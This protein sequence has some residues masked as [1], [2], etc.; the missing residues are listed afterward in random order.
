MACAVKSKYHKQHRSHNLRKDL[1]SDAHT[2]MRKLWGQ[3]GAAA[4]RFRK[5]KMGLKAEKRTRRRH[6]EGTPGLARAKLLLNR[7]QRSAQAEQLQLRSTVAATFH[8]M[9]VELEVKHRGKQSDSAQ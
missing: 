8:S 7:W 6:M 5:A 1:D 9:L 3:H 2:F 4:L